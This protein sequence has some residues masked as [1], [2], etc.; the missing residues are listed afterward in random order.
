MSHHHHCHSHEGHHDSCCAEESCDE[1]CCSCHHHHHEHNSFADD[2]LELADEAWMEV[3][4]EKIKD[5]IRTKNGAHLD[6]LAKLVSEA[7]NS[8]WSHRLSSQT[9]AGEFQDKIHDFF[10]KKG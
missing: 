6:K 4:K 3:L 7:N 5:H 8:R 1:C 2:L 9:E 10:H